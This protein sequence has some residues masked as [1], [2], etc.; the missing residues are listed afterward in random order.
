MII[1]FKK[2]QYYNYKHVYTTIIKVLKQNLHKL[3]N[4][5]YIILFSIFFFFHI[6]LS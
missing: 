5:L 1:I 3:F 6:T 2:K 4:L